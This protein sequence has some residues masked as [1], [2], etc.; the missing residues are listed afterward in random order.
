MDDQ[1]DLDEVG[2]V[3]G[4]GIS[5]LI[6]VKSRR[7]LSKELTHFVTNATGKFINRI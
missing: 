2:Q 6:A 3:D 7:N 1:Q 4:H 5:G